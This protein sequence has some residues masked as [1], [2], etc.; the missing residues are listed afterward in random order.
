MMQK[1]KVVLRK[2]DKLIISL[3][4]VAPMGVGGQLV[5]E[6]EKSGSSSAGG[7]QRHHYHYHHYHQHQQKERWNHT[8]NYRAAYRALRRKLSKKQQHVEG[9]GWEEIVGDRAKM[10]EMHAF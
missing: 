9:A 7:G 8:A 4:K 10:I 3:P 5:V 6:S 1:I 2:Q